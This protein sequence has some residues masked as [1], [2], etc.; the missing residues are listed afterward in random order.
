MFLY[1]TC[2]SFLAV[3]PWPRRPVE[4]FYDGD[5]GFCEI[6]RRWMERA[7]PYQ[8]YSWEKL[9][10]DRAQ[11]Q[12]GIANAALLERLHV[13]I[14]GQEIRS[15]FAAFKRMLLANPATYFMM[16]AAVLLSGYVSPAFRSVVIAAFV[17][18]F[19]PLFS[20]VGEALYDWVARNR[21]LMPGEKSCGVGEES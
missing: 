3:A 14:D 21:H 8:T 15:G 2:A 13:V 17:A 6:T 1:A 18:F 12:Y 20:P 16:L 9:Q 7:D 19:F 10:T 11:Q 5:C 4:V